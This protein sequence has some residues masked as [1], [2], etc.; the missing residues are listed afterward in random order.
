MAHH[1]AEAGMPDKAVGYRLKAGQRAVTR[2]AMSEA[3]AQ[4]QKGLDLLAILPANPWRQ[5]QELDLRT[6]LG[7]AL[8]A[9]KGLSAPDVGENYGQARARSE[10]LDRPDYLVAVLDGLFTFHGFRGEGKVAL[11]EQIERMGEVRNDPTL[12]CLGHHDHGIASCD[13]GDFV[14]AR[15]LFEKCHGLRD[16]VDRSGYV[17]TKL[18]HLDTSVLAWLAV[19]LAHL[20]YIDQGRARM[21]EALAEA[22]R[23]EHAHTLVIALIWAAWMENTASSPEDA[24]R[25]AEQAGTLSIEHGFPHW[26]GWACLHH[27][28]SLVALRQAEEGLAQLERGLSFLRATGSVVHTPLALVWLAEVYAKLARLDEGLICLTE[29]AHIIETTDQRCD[30]A[31]LHRVRGD[32]LNAAGDGAA[33]EK[34][35]HLALSVAR[36]QAA[37]IFELRAATSLARLWRDQGKQAEAHDLLAPIYGWF[38]EGFDTPVLKE[39]NALLDQLARGTS[40]PGA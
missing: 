33:A 2:S 13:L 34:N 26:Q 27:G 7:P 31:E 9:T 12:L 29:A 8:A 32:L 17:A 18:L 3:V 35:Y 24:R 14:A 10:Q 30:Q 11:A 38:S 36:P 1:C 20:G 22:R 40:P 37:R 23:I 25:Y 6:A 16:L 4:L 15:A 19:D 39:A 5:Q 21:R 28:R